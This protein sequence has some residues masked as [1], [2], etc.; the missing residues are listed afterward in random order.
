MAMQLHRMDYYNEFIKDKIQNN[1]FIIENENK[2]SS[3]PIE[4]LVNSSKYMDSEFRCEC[5]AF[6]GQDLI[7]QVCPRCKSEIILRGLNFGYTG[8][9]DLGEHCVIS[10]PYYEILKRVMGTN[11]LR[12]VLGDY[13][14]DKV[15]NYSGEAIEE[16]KKTKKPGRKSDDKIEVI[17]KKIPK[18]KYSYQ[19]LGHDVFRERF[20]EIVVSCASKNN[21]EIDILLNN[22]LAVFTNKIPIYSTAFRPVNK[23]SETMFYPRI[24]KPFTCMT[25]IAQ[26][27]PNMILPEE[28]ISALNYI[29]K[30]F[31]EAC[32]SEI[33][34]NI[35]K[36]EG[37]IRSEINGGT[38]SHSGRAVIS[39]DISL[40]AD[41]VD[42]PLSMLV[43]VYQYKLAHM[44][45]KRQIK[46]INRLEHAYLFVDKYEDNPEVL[47]LLDEI[48]AQNAWIFLLREPTNNL[49][50]IALC[51]IRNYKIHDDTISLPPE[52]LG[53]YNADFD[54]DA[55]DACFLPAE[56]APQFD[57]YHFSCMTD[58]VNEKININ[59]KE[60]CD[61]CLGI[62]SE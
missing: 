22:K 41:E 40:N 30:Y 59:L 43:T 60:W 23:T 31:I 54:G 13:I 1:G 28:K 36:K 11:M 32:E 34:I 21:P 18:S 8:W 37:I 29:Q 46:G 5:G 7:G 2:F 57:A 16:D 55:L 10:P 26:K 53:G 20:E 39:L 51:R 61:V 25:S 35:S 47:H 27:L 62:M 17:K 4:T 9:L 33:K 58:Y 45:V 15:V 19:G 50:S 49:A 24:N 3:V 12:F 56:L 42:I 6:F 44:V 48:L 38:F 14:E 52:P